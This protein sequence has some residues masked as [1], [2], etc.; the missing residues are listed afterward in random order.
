MN[1][2]LSQ[3]VYAAALSSG[4]FLAACSGEGS[5]VN[6]GAASAVVGV[7]PGINRVAVVAAPDASLQVAI[8]ALRERRLS[9]FLKAVMPPS[10]MDEMRAAWNEA[11]STEIDP[12]EDA[13]MI[14]FM[15]MAT[16]EG[17]EDTLFMM[18]KPY[19]KD[20]Q[21]QV[22]GMAQMLPFMVGGALNEAGAPEEAQAMLG[23]FSQKIIDIDFVSEEKARRAVGIFVTAARALK[24][25]SGKD[26]Q[27]LS[28]DEVMDRADIA[29]A[30]VVDILGVYGL[31]PD[32]MMKSIRVET[33]STSGDIAEMKLTFSLFGKEQESVPFQME[34]I[35]GRWFPKAPEKSAQVDD[36]LAR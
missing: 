8:D 5:D 10:Q 17:A 35:D 26:L 32:A 23:D 2:Q 25:K 16:A 22:E 13:Q 6:Q 19:L 20:V 12:K 14:A 4:L 18:F 27:V 31:S 7:N 30:G 24:I 15:S 9:A 33:V 29:Y 11:K 21:D 3:L 28:F 1:R 36:G 34:R